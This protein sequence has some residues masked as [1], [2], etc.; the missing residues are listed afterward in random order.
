MNKAIAFAILGLLLV[1]GLVGV[2]NSKFIPEETN[3][4]KKWA[5]QRTKEEFFN[6]PGG[7]VT[8]DHSGKTIVARK[9]NETTWKYYYPNY[10]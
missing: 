1:S 9:I 2:Y 6:R 8:I 7:I 3:L 10:N 4:G 5:D